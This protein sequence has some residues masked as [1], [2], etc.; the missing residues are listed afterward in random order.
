MIASIHLARPLIPTSG[1]PLEHTHSFGAQFAMSRNSGRYHS[2]YGC[3]GTLF[4]TTGSELGR[5][6]DENADVPHQTRT[7]GTR[8]TFFGLGPARPQA[9]RRSEPIISAP[10]H[11]DLSPPNSPRETWPIDHRK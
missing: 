6:N 8:R 4:K 9:S 3:F 10:Q 1:A 5:T 11:V 2:S 7:K